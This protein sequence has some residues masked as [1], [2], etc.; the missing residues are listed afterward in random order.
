M[1]NKII[2]FI[3]VFL[4][5]VIAAAETEVKT[6]AS[7]G[8]VQFEATGKPAMIKIK[9][10]GE[11]AQAN[12]KVVE[13]KISGELIFNIKS[14]KTGIELRD[15]HM[16][17]KYLQAEDFPQARLSIKD[18]ALPATWSV[19]N[20][21][22]KDQEFKGLLKLHGVEKEVSVKFSVES[23]RL[24][25]QAQFEV[26]LSDFSIDIP[27]YL[28]VKVADTVKVI[29]SFNEMSVGETSG[30]GKSAAKQKY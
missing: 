9:G 14:L 26:R 7:Q 10:Q 20:P 19:K 18:L 17:T 25:G 2:V 4:T 28:G 15:E 1:K 27:E 5:I 16:K 13:Q 12:L 6:N 3:S 8:Q 21:V 29:V 30:A 24:N 22:I 11:G 23:N